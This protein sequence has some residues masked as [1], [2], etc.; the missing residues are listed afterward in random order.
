MVAFHNNS[1]VRL[2]EY[3]AVQYS[4]HGWESKSEGSGG[5]EGEVQKV[6]GYVAG[7]RGL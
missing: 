5:E 2:G 3:S 6:A 7:A 1:V 4:F